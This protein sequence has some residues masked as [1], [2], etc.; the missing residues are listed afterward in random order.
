M[1]NNIKLILLI[2]STVLSVVILLFSYFGIL[3]YLEL[4]LFQNNRRLIQAYNSKKKATDCKVVVSLTN[5][6]EYNNS[7]LQPMFNSILDQTTRVDQIC[8]N[9]S[10][11]NNQDDIEKYKDI[12]NIYKI[13]KNFG[14]CTNFIPTLLREGNADTIIIVLPD[15]KYIFGKDYIE[16]LIDASQVYPDKAILDRNTEVIVIRP[17][18]FDSKVVDYDHDYCKEEVFNWI[19]NNLKTDINIISYAE[20]YNY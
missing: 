10:P 20:N 12:I 2:L 1:D 7:N 11:D 5:N 6:R 9:I 15:D 14:K 16:T 13:G 19:M 3:R 17:K 8:I 18:F 4:R